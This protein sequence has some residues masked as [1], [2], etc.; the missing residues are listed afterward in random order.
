MK[1]TERQKAEV[2]SVFS[3]TLLGPPQHTLLTDVM[4]WNRHKKNSKSLCAATTV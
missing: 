1:V 2:K 3:G 4:Q